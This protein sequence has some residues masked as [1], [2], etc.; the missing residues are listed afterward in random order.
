MMKNQ[1]SIVTGWKGQPAVE[2]CGVTG[3]GSGTGNIQGPDP[4]VTIKFLT[5]VSEIGRPKVCPDICKNSE[6]LATRKRSWKGESVQQ[7]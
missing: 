2:R 7:F 5:A 1:Y 6:N 3:E 4:K